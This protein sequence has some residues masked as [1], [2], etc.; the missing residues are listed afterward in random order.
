MERAKKVL[1]WIVY[2]KR[3]LDTAEICCALA[4]EPE[5]VELDP[6]NIPDIEDLVSVCAGLVVVDPESAIIRLVHYTA[7]EYFERIR[8]QWRPSALLEITSICLTYL[9]FDAFKSGSVAT[10]EEFDER[11]EQNNFLDYAAEHWGEHAITVEGEAC[12]Q[13][14]SFLLH[15]GLISCAAQVMS[16]TAYN[17]EG[18]SQRYPKKTTGLHLTARFGLPL[19]SEK[20]LPYQ[21]HEE[22]IA[23]T[24]KDSYDRTPLYLAAEHGHFEM[25]KWLLDMG[26]DVNAQGGYNWTALQAA[27]REGH[28]QIAKLLINK[29]ADVNAQ[30]AG[31]WGCNAVQKAFEEGDNDADINA[32]G[33]HFYN[34]LIAASYEGHEKIVRLLLDNGADVNAQ[35]GCIGNALKVASEEGHEQIVQL[36]LDNGADLNTEGGYDGNALQRASEEGYEQIVRLLLDNGADV[37]T[38]GENSTSALQRASEAGHDQIV[39]LL[40]GNGADV[41]TLGGHSTSAL[42]RASEAGHDQIVRLLLGNGADADARDEYGHNALQR[43]SHRG[44]D[45]IVQLL[46]DNGADAN[47]QDM[48]CG[49]ALQKA[50]EEGYEQI[51]QLLLSNGADVNA[52]SRHGGNALQ[53]ASDKGHG[54]I[55]RLLLDNGADI[56][57]RDGDFG[58]ALG[59][60]GRSGRVEVFKLLLEAGSNPKSNHYPSGS[61]LHLL[62]FNGQT[63]LLRLVYDQYYGTPL[64][65]ESHCPT[66]LQLTARGGHINAFQYLLSLGFDTAT[67][68]E[69]GENLLHYASSGGSLEILNAVLDIKSVPHTQ[70]EHWSPIHW[71]CRVGNPHLVERLIKEGINCYSV[72]VPNPEGQWS[73]VSIAIFHGK[74]KMFNEL[75]EHS[76]SLL[77]IGEDTVRL[78]GKFSEGFSC[79]G[80]FHVSG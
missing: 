72:T 66:P 25:A 39:R 28:E 1:Y 61:L 9:C 13:A 57:A 55:V 80:C 41:N 63:D 32:Q 68:D 6:E 49:N 74:E 45:Q 38:L 30:G 60:A 73:P 11:L 52:P 20:M 59:A 4:V 76:M 54:Q 77:D 2:A 46:L 71:A 69:K 5:E 16:A 64:L 22:A 53:R 79:D 34:A 43:A 31:G 29:G 36:L 50:S 47:A 58:D 48:C 40:L 3:P 56:N 65:F 42:Q 23:I 51:V 44:Y 78:H 27:S 18:Y 12:E 62:A 35:C 37:N 19:I 24:G 14:C 10:D 17:H 67:T 33:S 15:E 26:A 21:P 7:Q 8:E 75:S 70:S